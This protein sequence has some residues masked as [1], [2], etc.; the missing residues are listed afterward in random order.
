MVCLLPDTLCA[1]PVRS[2]APCLF[3]A[4]GQPSPSGETVDWS[5]LLR[6]LGDSA[7]VPWSQAAVATGKGGTKGRGKGGRRTTGKT[8]GE[9]LKVA[10]V[11]TQR[12][13]LK[14]PHHNQPYKA[15]CKTWDGEERLYSE[16]S[17]Q[18][19]ALCVFESKPCWSPCFETFWQHE[20]S[21]DKIQANGDWHFAY[22][23]QVFYKL[24]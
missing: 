7:W 21:K 9:S 18:S 15:K 20:R 22:Q 24:P 14:L 5:P 2:P 4:Q 13:K 12:M 8:Q 10:L 6:C 11:Q 17:I 1:G 23:E 3:L 16:D 19:S